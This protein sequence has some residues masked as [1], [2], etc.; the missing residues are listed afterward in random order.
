MCKEDC[1]W[2]PSTYIC[3]YIRYLKDI[4]DHLVFVYDEIM[5]VRDSVSANVTNAIITNVSHEHFIRDHITNYSYYQL[6]S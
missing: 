5:K 3:E 6:V 2:N 1:G 4:A